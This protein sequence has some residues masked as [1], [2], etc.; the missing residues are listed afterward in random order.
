MRAVGSEQYGFVQSEFE[1]P[2]V[3]ANSTRTVRNHTAAFRAPTEAG[4]YELSLGIYSAATGR[5]IESIRWLVDTVDFKTLGGAYQRIY[6]DGVPEMTIADGSATLKLPALISGQGGRSVNGLELSLYAQSS[7]SLSGGRRIGTYDFGRGLSPGSRI[8]STTVTLD[9][10]E[11]SKND[12]V[13]LQILDENRR[14]VLRLLIAAPEGKDLPNNNFATGDADMLVDSDDD[15]VGDVNEKLMGTDPDDADSKPG[16]VTVDVLA[17]YYP[18]FAELYDGDPTTRIRHVMTLASSIY[19]DSDTGVTLRTLGPVEVTEDEWGT[20]LKESL[21]EQHSADVVVLF[22]PTDPRR[23]VCG[24]GSLTGL[25][26]NGTM[27]LRSPPSSVVYGNCGA[28]TAAHEIGHNMG[29]GHSI[30]QDGHGTFRWARGYGVNLSFVTVM[31]Y[32]QEYGNAPRID[33]FSDPDSDCKGAPCGVAIDRNNGADS[34]QALNVTR[35]QIARFAEGKPDTDGDGFVDPIDALPNDPSDHLDTDGDGIGNSTDDDDD[36]DG[37]ADATDL[38]PLDPNESADGDGDGIG[39]NADAFPQDPL[40]WADTDGDGVGDKSDRFPDDPTETKDTDNDGVGNNTDAFPFDTRDWLDTDGDGVGDNLDDDADGDGVANDIDVFPLDSVRSDASS[41]RLNLPEGA[42]QSLSLSSA[43]DIDGDGRAD[44]LVGVAN[45]ESGAG[46]WTSAVYL[47]AAGDLAAADDADGTADRIVESSQLVAQPNSWKFVD[48]N[49]GRYVGMRSAAMV[50]DVDGD[51]EPEMLIGAPSHGNHDGSGVP[52]IAYLISLADLPTADTADGNTDGVVQLSRI[53]T[54]S[55]SWRLVGE[56]GGD[57]A[58]QSVQGLGDIDGDDVPD[59]AVGA[60]GNWWE[61]HRKGAIYVISG[62]DLAGADRADG[63][64]D[65]TIELG[66]V[67][68]RAD[69]WK[70]IDET[71]GGFLGQ[72]GPV[73]HVGRDNDLQFIMAASGYAGQ[74]GQSVGAAYVVSKS[75]WAAGDAADGTTDGIVDVGEVVS[76]P[77]SWRMVGRGSDAVQYAASIGDHNGDEADDILVRSTRSAFYIS[78]A[79]LNTADASDGSTDGQILVH[80]LDLQ[81]GWKTPVFLSKA[82]NNGGVAKGATDGDAADDILIQDGSAAYLISGNDFAAIHSSETVQL[83]QIAVG[84]GSW[85]F[86]STGNQIRGIEI[87]GDVNADGQDD[88]LFLIDRTIFVVL[89]SELS[90]L[91]A[92]DDQTNGWIGLSQMVGDADGDGVGNI[93]DSDDDDDG[94]ADFEDAFPHD[95]NEW[96]DSDYD[97]VGDNSDAFP[98]DRLEQF[99]T[100]LDGIGDRADTD[101]DGD[102]VADN[103][104]DYP[105]DTD[106]DAIDN[107]EDPDDDNDGVEDGDDAFPLDSEETA[108]FDGDGV[109][110]NADTD[111]DNDGVADDADDLPFNAAETSDRDED[112]VGDNSD[113]F[114]DDPDETLDTDADGTGNNADT[115]DDNDGTLDADDAFPLDPAESADTDGDG[116]GDNADALPDDA[117]EQFD[118][119]G[120]GIGNVADT[121]DDNDGFSDGADYYPLD[122]DRGRLFIFEVKGEAERAWTGR[123]HAAAGDLNADDIGEVLV[124]APDE[125][126]PQ[127]GED[128]TR[129]RRGTVHVISGAELE[130]ADRADGARDGQV[131]IGQIAEQDTYW[132]IGGQRTGD[133]LGVSLASAGDLDGDGKPDWMLG[134]SGRNDSTAAAYVVSS[135]DLL[136]RHPVGSQSR[137]AEISSLLS[138]ANTWELTGEGKS[139]EMSA[140]SHV[141]LAG[142]TDGDGKPELLIGTPSYVADDRIGSADTGAAYLVSS[143]HLTTANAVNRG[144]RIDIGRLRGSSGAWKFVGEADGDKAGSSVL[145]VGDFDGDGLADIAIGASAHTASRTEEGAIYLVAAADLADADAADGSADRTIQLTN[146]RRQSASWKLIGESWEHHVGYSMTAADVN[147]NGKLELIIAAAGAQFGTG[148]F[149]IVP[150]EDLAEADSADGSADRVVNLGQ[151]P[152]L[153]DAWKLLGEGESPSYARTRRVPEPSVAAGDLDRDGRA[154]LIFGVP[155]HRGEPIRCG[156]ANYTN[157]TGAVYVLSGAAL[158]SADE[159]DGASDGEILLSNVAGQSNSWKLLGGARYYL[160][161]SVAAVNDLDGDGAMDIA[162]GAPGKLGPAEDCVATTNDPGLTFIASSADLIHSDQHDGASDGIIHLGSLS[163]RYSAI[164]FDFDGIEDAVDD[165]DDNDGY[166]DAA[167]VFPKNPEEWADNDYDGIGDNADP[168]DDN[169]G[170]LDDDDPFPNDPHKPGDDEDGGAGNNADRDGVANAGNAFPLDPSQ[171]TDEDGDGIGDY[172]DTDGDGLRNN[173]DPDDDNDG[174]LDTDDLFPLNANKSDLF[175]YKLSGETRT[176]AESDFDGDGKDDL[177]VKSLSAQNRVYLISAA[178]IADVDDDDGNL[179]RLVDFDKAA[180]LRNSWKFTG[181]SEITHLAPAGDVDF[182]GR[183]DVVVAGREGTF[184]VPMASMPAADLADNQSD[185]S[186]TVSR[187]LEGPTVGAWRLTAP[188]LERGMYSLADANADGHTELLIGAPLVASLTSSVVDRFGG[189]PIDTKTSDSGSSTAYIASGNGWAAADNLDGSIDG[190]IVLDQWIARAKAYK[191]SAQ[192]G[193]TSGAIVAGAGDFDGDGYEDLMVSVPGASAGAVLNTQSVY[194]LSGMKLNAFDAADGTIDGAIDLNL[195]LGAG[196]WQLTEGNFDPERVL[197]TVGDIDGD[198]MSDMA[199]AT[200]D[201][202]FLIAAGD[203]AAADAADGA[204]DR[205]INVANVVNQPGSYKFAVSVGAS[206]GFRVT[207]VGDIDR[208][209]MD[210]ILLVRSDSSKA[211]L[212]TAK[213]FGT[214]TATNGIVSLTDTMS[215][216]NSWILALEGSDTLFSGTG[217]SGDLDGYYGPELVIGVRA[218]SDASAEAA[219]VISAAEFAV[220]DTLDNAQD[221]SIALDSVFERWRS[222]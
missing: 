155:R 63:D 140:L 120:D 200:M 42:N 184:V 131:D 137:S 142:D 102:G 58:G 101:D 118:T 113:A 78:A 97:G 203:M 99:D 207:G 89:S 108:D 149:Y 16:D 196:F 139:D 179:D 49:E 212:I 222:D 214:M 67:A 87:P 183:D 190:V 141:A 12:Y 107:V 174:V 84:G 86:E 205:V 219:Y 61:D 126:N 14:Y 125:P 157:E 178:D 29:L 160:G 132:S 216:P 177:I 213:D 198:G 18:S 210:D 66:R 32:Q 45:Y 117:S 154:D 191:L 60:P 124:G 38:F 112:G 211:H 122:A 79:H 171:W 159:A 92:A 71:E 88:L 133:H 94:V 202:I 7:P 150:L 3:A 134:A 98:D 127:Y 9:I 123:A 135:T 156:S 62:A 151:I 82:N 4:T 25:A 33:V 6:F 74:D 8:P 77:K 161:G 220:A 130:A 195:E 50:G 20:E 17:V 197:G 68:A 96:A 52:G 193:D 51:D 95:P 15:G 27:L 116:V 91:D 167:D 93:L 209:S 180:F 175:F 170:V 106:N 56:A 90:V 31:A 158:G 111:D 206:S 34:A 136:S 41:Y 172:A 217:F 75:D 109:G 103:D 188:K 152:S 163:E 1:I 46:P 185:R 40:E 47:V 39:D 10:Q 153:D 144:S 65:G 54:S 169:D 23:R 145:S 43:G 81:S 186:I 57:S 110:N 80:D 208:D 11:I 168:D 55:N 189:S 59:L 162:L 165:D 28:S 204:S 215:L 2:S 114:P 147:G 5:R 173:V 146:V 24:I 44:F 119:D 64:T 72:T 36:G 26:E 22:R 187:S 73:R 104:D 48:E 194:L 35:F 21:A 83:N 138:S 121:D 105:L 19:G 218:V 181:V 192:A 13:S 201:G 37:V 143:A 128:A 70:L 115:D 85:R 148:I 199:I 166:A 221:R 30:V 76:Q 129:E 100:D 164:D 176:L 182:D 69:S 53:P